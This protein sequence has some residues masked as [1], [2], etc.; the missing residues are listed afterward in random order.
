MWNNAKRCGNFNGFMIVWPYVAIRFHFCEFQEST[1]LHIVSYFMARPLSLTN[2]RPD[3]K[4]QNL[5][6]GQMKGCFMDYCDSKNLQ[7]ISHF[8]MGSALANY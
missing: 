2:L 5:G 1:S 4:S 3:F 8:K 6:I 7:P